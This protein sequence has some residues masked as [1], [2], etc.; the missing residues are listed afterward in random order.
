VSTLLMISTGAGWRV[1]GDRLEEARAKAEDRSATV[2]P[3][4]PSAALR[5]LTWHTGYHTRT[6]KHVSLMDPF[7]ANRIQ[8][9][10]NRSRFKT[11]DRIVA[12]TQAQAAPF[13]FDR[14]R[15]PVSVI[16]DATR[17]LYRTEFGATHLKDSAVERERELFDRAHHVFALSEWAA[18][19]VKNTYGISPE[20][21]T[22]IPPLVH[23][24]APKDLDSEKD[25]LLDVGFIGNDFERKGGADLLRWHRD[26]MQDRVRLHILG[27]H[28]QQRRVQQ[29]V[30]WHGSVTNSRVMR[31]FLPSMDVLCLPTYRDCSPLVVGEAAM[32]GVPAVVSAV[33]GVGELVV[34][35]V[36]GFTGM[37]GHPDA[38]VTA[39]LRLAN[40]GSLVQRMARAARAHAVNSFSSDVIYRRL[41]SVSDADPAPRD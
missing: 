1:V 29:N 15:R 32:V 7:T 34:E 17:N 5:R 21:V 35:G 40:D 30:V 8:V 25:G 33:G 26:Y 3:Y 18:T 41:M 4:T 39:L 37:P 20:R 10:S 19:D 12:A 16:I 9:L 38:F 27:D 23:R 28:E 13:V 24:G 31:E 2:V 11:F 14:S 36:T 22:V 6:P